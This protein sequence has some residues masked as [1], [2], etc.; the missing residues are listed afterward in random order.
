MYKSYEELG[1][2]SEERNI[3]PRYEA[4]V[5]EIRTQEE[6][7]AILRKYPIVCIDIYADWCKPCKMIEPRFAELAIKYSNDQCILVKENHA[8][9][10]SRDVQSL[11]YFQ[12]YIGGKKVDDTIGAD[13]K[14]VEEKLNRCLESLQSVSNI[15]PQ[16][17]S[18]RG[19]R[20][21]SMPEETD[22]YKKLNSDYSP[23][24]TF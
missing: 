23:Y 16:R 18:I 3:L 9:N 14:Q 1:V 10:L 7:Q 6:K 21:M 17:N 5:M 2:S 8:L 12:F 20:T 11:P 4:K 13:I 24:S 19:N 15:Q 22:T